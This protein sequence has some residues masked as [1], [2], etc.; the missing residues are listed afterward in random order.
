MVWLCCVQ[1]MIREGHRT[2]QAL[3]QEQSHKTFPLV[4]YGL[5]KA[6]VALYR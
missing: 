2:L 5:G 1:M 6:L 4:I 3:Y